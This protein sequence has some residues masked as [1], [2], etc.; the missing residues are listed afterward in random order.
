MLKCWV[1]LILHVIEFNQVQSDFI[2]YLIKFKLTTM[3]VNIWKVNCIEQRFLYALLFRRL[4][5][6]ENNKNKFI[7][8]NKF[9]KDKCTKPKLNESETLYM[10]F[11]NRETRYQKE[12]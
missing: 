6:T 11:F 12:W 2:D 9:F 10:F 4:Y 5:D 8:S 7:I 3:I 1:S